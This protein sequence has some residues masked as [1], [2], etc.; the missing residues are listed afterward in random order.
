MRS[1]GPAPSLHSMRYSAGPSG[2]AGSRQSE[3]T[4]GPRRKPP[5]HPN[6]PTDPGELAAYYRSTI[7]DR[8]VLLVFDNASDAEQVEALL[9]GTASSLVLTTSR[10]DL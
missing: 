7:A 10:R 5:S 6:V 3:N 4:A 8:R 1:R 9:P 2:C